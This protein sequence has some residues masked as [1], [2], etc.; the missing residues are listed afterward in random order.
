MPNYTA[1]ARRIKWKRGMPKMP[2]NTKLVS[3]ASRW[4]NPWAVGDIAENLS[5]MPIFPC[6]ENTRQL[7]PRKMSFYSNTAMRDA[8]ITPIA[9]RAAVDMFRL[10]AENF[11]DARPD[12]FEE[13]I[14]PLRGHDLACACE[15]GLPCHADVLLE[16]A[17][18]E[19]EAG[20]GAKE[21]PNA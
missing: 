21:N 20:R 9:T 14:A 5:I 15:V 11:R 12:D 18:A 10:Y 19:P 7:H 16:L 17:A 1:K 3:R 8:K 4:G 6:D 2:P 13:W